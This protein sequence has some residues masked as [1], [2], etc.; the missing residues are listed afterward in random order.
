MGPTCLLLVSLTL[1]S[2]GLAEEPPGASFRPLPEPA[3]GAV[4]FDRDVK[5]LLE[6]RCTK[7][8]GPE[9][10]KG[11]LRL[12]AGAEILKGGNSGSVVL[13]G[14]SAD[15]LLIHLVAG[16]EPDRSMPPGGPNLTST[17][18]GKLRAWIDQGAKVPSADAQSAPLRLASK[19]W[20]FQPI[21]PVTPPEV[22]NRSWVRTPI[23]QFILAR[24]EREGVS[25]SP[26]A[27]K[28]TL[29]RRVYLDLIGLPPRIDEIDDFL[30]DES[31]SA[32]ER[33]VDRLLASPHYGERWGRHW[34]DLARY[35]D[36]D[37][38]EKD[39]G[40]PHAWRYRQ[41]VIDA[42]NRDLP[43]DQFTI[44][45]LAGDLLPNPT[46]EQLAATGFHRNTLTNLEGGTDP[47]EFRVA[48]VNDR[49]HTTAT[50]W[51]GLTMSC[52]QCHDHKYDSISQREYYQ[53][54]A[55][56]NQDEEVFV[57]APLPG[58]RAAHAWRTWWHNQHR[59][60][61]V[62]QLEAYRQ[63]HFP[64][65]QAYWEN[66]LKLP[67][68][69]QLPEK[70]QSV[71]LLEPAKRSNEQQQQ[72]TDFYSG[73]DPRLKKFKDALAK[74][75][76]TQPKLT[77]APALK[78]G[79]VRKTH[80]HI[81]GDFLR[82]GVEVTPGTPAILPP[83]TQTSEVKV[84][85]AGPMATSNQ[86]S[87]LDLARWLVSAEQPLTPR[88][89][90]NWVW[91]NHFGRGMVNT[92]EDF[93]VRGE[94]PSH[95]ELLDWLAHEF[96][97]SGWSLK[98]LHR[99]IVTSAVYRQ[100]AVHRPELRDRD[101]QNVWLAR[102][103]RLRLEAELIRDGALAVSGLLNRKVG[104]PSVRPP[105]P[106]GIAEL[107]YANSNRWIES[108][109]PDRFRRGLYIWFQRT[110]PY[111]MLISFDAPESNVCAAK[112]ERTNTPL[113][114]L[115]LLNDVVFVEAAQAFGRR[116]LRE[117]PGQGPEADLARITLAM[118]ICLA[119][120]PTAA[121]QKTLSRLLADFR[122]LASQ[123]PD[124]SALSGPALPGV[125]PQEQAAWVAFARAL[126][127]LD[128]FITR[129]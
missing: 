24:L 9:K 114:A 45:Q 26:E 118:R 42:L 84:A 2:A 19:H 17:E 102:Q 81:R 39:L 80:V 60:W 3:V 127:N 53:L 126:M 78:L 30:H 85:G 124:P 129:E 59:P 71:L 6:A 105:Q 119:R 61:L 117:E 51:L 22:K 72:L 16:L 47:E 103:N 100:S 104:G 66:N 49:V 109:G 36:S 57:E 11:G 110:S 32:Y 95:P 107:T 64:A 87:R 31:D 63:H 120:P 23:D 56:F 106:Q 82:K 4:E 1:T 14:K 88:V 35:A 65:A 62:A 58:E 10:Q 76:Q 37:G 73:L 98:R 27:D 13:P 128:E 93:G 116:L 67:E 34:L 89:I 70:I 68:L 20:S 40:R 52:A 7:C 8:H 28:L 38:Y 69:R 46:S 96:R 54:F 15:S 18:I 77:Q 97:G 5:P 99:L 112:R 25:P 43:F 50:V 94:P 33:L 48:A 125:T 29:L 44:E 92:P 41:W 75:D 91:R 83:L 121:E 21:R 123:S 86:P 90:V 12:D 79:T 74:F 122:S 108:T 55:F 101:P 115:T 111:P 113:Q